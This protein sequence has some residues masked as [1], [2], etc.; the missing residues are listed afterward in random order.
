MVVS[1]YV[2]F[3]PAASVPTLVTGLLVPLTMASAIAFSRVAGRP[4]VEEG[5][6]V[7]V[8]VGEDDE[9]V[10]VAD[11]VAEGTGLGSSF[12]SSFVSCRFS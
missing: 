12:G 11:D 3:L 4:A 6:V 8:A 9:D 2:D 1:E 10:E 5:V 7:E